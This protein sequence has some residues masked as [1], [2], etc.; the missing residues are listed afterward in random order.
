MSLTILAQLWRTAARAH[1]CDGRLGGCTVTIEKGAR[2]LYARAVDD[3]WSPV[4]GKPAKY[5]QIE[6]WCAPCGS[7][8]ERHPRDPK[9]GAT[10][11]VIERPGA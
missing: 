11:P 3:G 5:F 7:L 10:G 6:R 4:T 2:Y 1:R 8:S 9:A